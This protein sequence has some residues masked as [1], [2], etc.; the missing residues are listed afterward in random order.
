[1]IKPQMRV[2]GVIGRPQMYCIRRGVRNLED[3]S[4]S[5]PIRGDGDGGEMWHSGCCSALECGAS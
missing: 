5:E 3:F 2:R 4:E 1:M